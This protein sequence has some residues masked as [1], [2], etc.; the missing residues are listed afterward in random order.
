MWSRARRLESPDAIQTF[1]WEGGFDAPEEIG[2]IFAPASSELSESAGAVG[3]AGPGEGLQ[4]PDEA[5]PIEPAPPA[6]AEVLA[7]QQAHLAALERDAFA[8]G[9]AQGERAGF[10]AGGTRAEAMLRRLASSLEELGRLRTSMIQQTERQ[11]VQLALVVARRILRREASVDADLVVAMARVALDRLGERSHAKVRMHPD[12][13]AAAGVPSETWAGPHVTIVPDAS[14]G[15][16]QCQVESDF[17]FVEAG[18]EAQ[19]EQI[20]Q[21]LL[22]PEMDA[23]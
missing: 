3:P 8:T 22:G 10:E 12:D 6:L 23:R 5:G 19:F 21:A 18:V 11:M 13:L 14:L 9:Y 20:A 15:R 16:G 4:P 17:G 1:R 7:E 2:D